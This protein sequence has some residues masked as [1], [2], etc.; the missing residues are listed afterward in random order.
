MGQ[1]M[2]A[3]SPSLISSI[4][5]CA[6]KTDI[7]LSNQKAAIQAFRLMDINDEVRL[8]H[9]EHWRLEINYCNW[10]IVKKY[11]MHNV[12]FIN[13]KFDQ[14]Q[15]RN[16]LM[17]VY[18]DAQSPV[19]KRVAAYLILMR[20]PDQARV[21]DIVNILENM[22]DKQLKSFVV[23]HLNNIRNSDEPQMHQWVISHR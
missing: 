11:S 14:P 1:A 9:T 21:R 6:K 2:Q 7:P 3:V 19:E 20:N 17:E 16:V 15:V 8:L 23:S 5:R 13:V 4:L 18:Q 22:R 10:N 12:I